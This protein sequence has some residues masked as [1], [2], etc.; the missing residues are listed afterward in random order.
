MRARHV[1]PLTAVVTALGLLAA[2]SAQSAK[3]RA[4]PPPPSATPAAT[5]TPAAA[6]ATATTAEPTGRTVWLCRPDRTPNP[7]TVNT[8]TTAVEA[9]GTHTLLPQPKPPTPT[10]DCF[11]VYPT[12]STEKTRNADLRVQKAERDVAFAQ[13]SRFSTVCRVWA[14]M[15]RQRT[16]SDLFNLADM[17]RDSK[18]NTVAFSSLLSAWR[19]YIAHDNH[20]RTI[21][22]IGH[23]QG[24]AMLIRLLGADV[25]PSPALRARVA[26]AIVLGGNLTVA[27][28]EVVGGSFQHL[29]LCTRRG[30]PGCVLAYSSFPRQPPAGAFFGRPGQ[31]VSMLSGERPRTGVDVACV[32]PSRIGGG[33]APVHPYLPTALVHSGTLTPWTTYPDRY[34]SVCRHADGATWLQVS[35]T[36]LRHDVRPQLP[37]QLGSLW[38]YHAVDVNLALGDLVDDTADA[39]AGWHR[40]H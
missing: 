20:G 9:D 4:Q 28:G 23:S 29:P 39:I 14:P 32:N 17:A 6:A 1:V 11:Y 12:V 8:A 2:C 5:S 18:A 19:D 35:P 7:C 22:F 25:D 33:P 31:G 15:Y 36:H 3:P 26:L 40:Q 30:Q 27:S 37:E 34:T 24:A 10:A 38:G 13:A 21:V 16:M